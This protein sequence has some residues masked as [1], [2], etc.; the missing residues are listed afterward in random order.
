MRIIRL[1]IALAVVAVV[2]DPRFLPL[3]AQSPE[4]QAPEQTQDDGV[5]VRAAARN[6]IY[7]VQMADVPAGSY[8]G[9]VAGLPATKAPR[10]QKLDPNS[11]AVVG[12][13]TFLRGRHDQALARVGGG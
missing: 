7:I 10:G 12:Y 6:N 11:P 3:A 13:G 4:P 1:V 9:G 2:A 5:R 8:T